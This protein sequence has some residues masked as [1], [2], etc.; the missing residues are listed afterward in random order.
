MQNSWLIREDR[1]EYE[2]NLAN[3]SSLFVNYTTDERAL[4]E[5]LIEYFQVRSKNKDA[6]SILDKNDEYEAI[7]HQRF[8]AIELS[9]DILRE[10]MKLGAKSLLKAQVKKNLLSNPEIDGYINTINSLLED[11]INQANTELPIRP[12]L[13]TYDSMIKMM[14]VDIGITIENETNQIIHQ[15]K[16]L[17]PILRNFIINNYSKPT[18]VVYFYPE[19]YLSPKEQR[20]MR[21]LLN[22]FSKR[23][24]V[25]VLTKSKIFIAENYEGLNYF[26]NHV[27][28]FNEEFIANL[29]WDCPIDYDYVEIKSS[30]MRIIYRYID[31]FELHPTVS[32]YTDAD[33]ILFNSLDLYVF[34]S[35]M[36]KLKFSYVFDLEVESIDLPVYRYI[37]DIYEK[38]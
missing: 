18:F 6:I 22:N 34:A 17:L 4:I 35:I 8:A 11:L 12:K 23:I 10:E 25:F 7:N 31:V 16:T 20:E 19:T 15:N 13:F 5:P 38:M 24:P 9:N 28:V 21:Q 29:E 27:Q 37:M 14:E 3:Y 32:N 26:V 36:K 2:V 30:I 1:R 33:V